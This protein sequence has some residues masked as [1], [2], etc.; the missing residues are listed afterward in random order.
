MKQTKNILRKILIGIATICL[1]L[2]IGITATYFLSDW[3]HED[4]SDKPSLFLQPGEN[5][6]SV[7]RRRQ[8]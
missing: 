4:D 8:I 6:T 1:L 5:Q 2:A 7:L 3:Y